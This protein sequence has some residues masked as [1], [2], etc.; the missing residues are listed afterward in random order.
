[1]HRILKFGLAA[2]VAFAAIV[3]AMAL[4]QD[5]LLFPTHAVARAQ[6]LPGG[7]QRIS[8]ERPGG[9]R[10]SGVH[11]P[12]ATGSNQARTLV[13]GFGGNAWNGDDV[14]S[15]LHELYPQAHVV[16][17]HYRGY[18]PSTGS[19]SAQALIEDAPDVLGAA[20]ERVMPQRT[21]AVG[22]SIGSAIAARLARPPRVD[23]LILVTPFDSLKAVAG[24][25]YPWLP[26]NLLF[27]H[28]MDAVEMLSG[29]QLPVAIVSAGSDEIIP[30]ARTD[31]LREQLS[32]VVYDRSIK[33][34]GHN[35]IYG[36]SDFQQAMR[37][38]FEAVAN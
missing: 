2:L 21:V 31:A 4:F 25:L 3:A 12:P 17:F 14:A 35:D 9:V 34:A 15:Y 23:G 22:F 18:R 7:A 16:V 27:R 6:P 5:Q 11:I 36:R 30:T 24:D 37:D 20:V 10:L 29:A 26:V 28:E 8:L 38:A 13:L 33:G 32:T 19:P 1:V